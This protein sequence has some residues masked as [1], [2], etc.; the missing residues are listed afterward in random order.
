MRRKN[1][2]LKGAA[3]EQGA[4]VT[5]DG[6]VKPI[7]GV[8]QVAPGAESKAIGETSTVQ[9]IPKVPGE[10]I[11]PPKAPGAETVTPPTE[12]GAPD[13]RMAKYTDALAKN[14]NLTPA[15]ITQAAKDFNLP[16][17]VVKAY[18]DSQVA[19]LQ[20]GVQGQI[21]DAAHSAVG[22]EAN[23]KAF[24][25]WANGNMEAAEVSTMMEALQ[26]KSAAVAKTIVAQAYEAFKKAGGGPGPTDASR[27]GSPPSQ[28]AGATG[29][30]SKAEQNAAIRDPKYKSDPA[31]RAQVEA[32]IVASRFT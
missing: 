27:G 10:E 8:T 23:W 21:I 9:P 5:A 1:R 6:E 25:E 13:P 3:K 30:A 11:P 4:Q 7:G 17:N 29:F 22:G 28:G 15:E 19:S 12:T 14:G 32:R 26:G 16:E 20:S 31:Y 24:A 18:V 2:V